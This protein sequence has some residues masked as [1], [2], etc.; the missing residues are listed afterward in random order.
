MR[1][2]NILFAI[3]SLT[4]INNP[5]Y[6]STQPDNNL[7]QMK[8]PPNIVL[9]V[10]DDLGWSD[11]SSYGSEIKTPN[12]DN[13]AYEGIQFTSFYASVSCSP[14]RAMLMT[15]VDNHQ[16]GI[17][18]MS[19]LLTDVQRGKPGY[20]GHLNN[21]VVTLP[22]VLK[23]NGYNTYMAGKWHLGHN[24]EHWPYARG[25]ERS[26]SMLNG[27]ASHWD[28]MYGLLA[29]VEEKATYVRDNNELK[30][31]PKNFYSTTAYTD[32]IIKYIREGRKNEKP[33]FAYLAFTAPHD[34]LH[35]PEPWLSE[36]KGYYD[37]GYQSLKTA[38]INSDKKLGLINNEAPNAKMH[39]MV[40]PWN[41]L[42]KEQKK[43]ETK[44]METY[45]GMISNMDYN[46]GRLKDFL[47]DI[48]EYDNT[49]FIFMS[50]NGAN[51]WYSDDYPVNK[52]S[53]FMAQFDNSANN[54][55][56]PMSHYAYGIGWASASNGP[57]DRFKMTV[58]EGGIRVPLLISGA[59]INEST[60]PNNSFIY[61]TDIMPTVLDYA[62]IKNTVT[63][64]NGKVLG[65]QGKSIR[66]HLEGKEEIIHPE[67]DVF[68]GEMGLKGKWARSGDFKAA[69]Q[70]K[71][72]GDGV[73]KLFN[74]SDDPGE[75]I[76]I[77]KKYPKKL[78][79]L[80]KEWNAYAEHVGVIEE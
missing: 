54:I 73:W 14:T 41:K 7:S 69:M 35:V 23:Y 8:Q 38:R 64:G 68:C 27:G 50:D 79:F 42:T 52:G 12:I 62:N 3:F 13:I 61:V 59:G 57:L 47:S 17:G 9:I 6:A 70:P 46:V 74:I 28:D 67:S 56:H 18:N 49:I 48:N 26:F 80:M 76:D 22:E 19:E 29:D 77:S 78:Q 31:L 15:S 33:F 65:M 39:P 51:P 20:E 36:Y 44:A 10:A 30:T 24:K 60:T 21:Q 4:A 58:G 40:T 55:G 2:N 43:I 16:A 72:F 25:F 37:E 63:H 11:L 71:P 75:T 5:L 66:S 34:P 32:E 45:A 1:I 53:S